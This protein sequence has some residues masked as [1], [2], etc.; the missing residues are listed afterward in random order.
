[1]RKFI[2]STVV[3][4]CLFTGIGV[5]HNKADAQYFWT[6]RA[7]SPTAWGVGVSPSLYTARMG[8]LQEC[9]WRTPFWQTCFIVG[10]Q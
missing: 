10:C 5:A 6:C 9:R 4:V 7:E 8:A 2:I 1:M 3:A